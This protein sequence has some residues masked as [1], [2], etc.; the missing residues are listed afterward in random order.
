MPYLTTPGNILL[1]LETAFSPNTPYLTTPVSTPARTVAQDQPPYVPRNIFP[2]S[3][4][5]S[6]PNMPYP[7]TP[8]VT[9][10][11]ATP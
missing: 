11:R 5:S 2:T 6:P 10:V 1:T 9:P 3:E 4:T 7:L 8:A